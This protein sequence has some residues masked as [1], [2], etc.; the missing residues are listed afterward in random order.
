MA[1]RYAQ[2]RDAHWRPARRYRRG[3][4]SAELW[5]WLLD[6]GSLTRRLRR[7]CRHGFRVVVRRQV[8]GRPSPD[9]RRALGMA[10]AER[11]WIREVH[12]L[13]GDTPWVF[14]RTV[15]PV[16]SLR[17]RER[18]LSRLGNKP[19]G[20]ALFADPGLRR[21]GVEVA[22][23]ECGHALFG[24]AMTTP[25][26]APIWG[27]RSVFRLRGRPLL[28]SE[29]FLPALLQAPMQGEPTLVKQCAAAGADGA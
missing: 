7:C 21:G 22:R 17:G 27:R 12:L 5:D 25:A 2:G 15:L 26:T 14:A 29:I 16:S 18:R 8:W 11:A 24:R 23:L 10:A 1:H 28:V 9:E 20:A 4:V 3:A 6:A 19:L 13:C